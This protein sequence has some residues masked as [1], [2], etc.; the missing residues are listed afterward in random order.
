MIWL[1]IVLN[2][3]DGVVFR[4]VAIMAAIGE[5]NGVAVPVAMQ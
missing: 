3:Y 5:T 1:K 2:E 4:A